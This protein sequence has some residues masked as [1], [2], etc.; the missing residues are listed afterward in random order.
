MGRGKSLAESEK[1]LIIKE[2]AKDKTNKPIDERI[3]RGDLKSMSKRYMNRLKR[4][5]RV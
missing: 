5:V 4:S 3:I 2:I 1:A